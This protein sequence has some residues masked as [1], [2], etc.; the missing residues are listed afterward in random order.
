MNSERHLGRVIG[1]AALA[2]ML[3][4]CGSTGGRP[5]AAGERPVRG[6]PAADFAARA[7]AAAA[8]GKPGAVLAYRRRAAQAAPGDPQRRVQLAQAYLAV[9]RNGAAA[10]T[11]R[12]AIEMAGR[13]DETVRGLAAAQLALGRVDTARAMLASLERKDAEIAFSGPGLAL[14]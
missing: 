11:F 1:A 9:G 12:D 8:E 6:A 13:T 3:A 7:D 4:A 5:L 14:R 2:T 10:A